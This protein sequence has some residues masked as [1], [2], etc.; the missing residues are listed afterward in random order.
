VIATGPTDKVELV[1]S[2][3][4]I[5]SGK[6]LAYNPTSGGRPANRA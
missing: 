2:N 5:I 1:P 4:Y 3:A 6:M